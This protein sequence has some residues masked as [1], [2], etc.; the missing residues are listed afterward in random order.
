MD[1]RSFLRGLLGTAALVTVAPKTYILPPSGGW[2]M[3]NSLWASNNNGTLW[4]QKTPAEILADVNRA[5]KTYSFKD[6]KGALKYKSMYEGS[7]IF[8]EAELSSLDVKRSFP[9][10]LSHFHLNQSV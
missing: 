5:L 3:S 2:R 9:L 8:K 4:S 7:W 1:R 6:V 10:H